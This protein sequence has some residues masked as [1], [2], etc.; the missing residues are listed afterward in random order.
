MKNIKKI[1]KYLATLDEAKFKFVI[2]QMAGGDTFKAQSEC[3]NPCS[4]QGSTP[5][6][7]WTHDSHCICVWI[8]EFG[9]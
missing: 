6:G 8:P 2:Q 1:A 7:Y 3:S 9:G 4:G 5:Y